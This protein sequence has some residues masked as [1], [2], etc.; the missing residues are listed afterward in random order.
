MRSQVAIE[1]SPDIV[2]KPNLSQVASE[3]STMKVAVSPSN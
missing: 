2:P 3:H 1:S